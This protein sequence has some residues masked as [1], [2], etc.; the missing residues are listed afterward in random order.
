MPFQIMIFL[1]FML[2]GRITML[3]IGLIMRVPPWIYEGEGEDGCR[4]IFIKFYDE[5]YINT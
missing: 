3:T 1:Y 4:N 5:L 2:H